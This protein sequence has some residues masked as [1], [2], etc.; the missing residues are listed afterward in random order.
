MTNRFVNVA[1]TVCGDANVPL[2]HPDRTVAVMTMVGGAVV[3]MVSK[4]DL[5]VLTPTTARP[6]FACRPFVLPMT[7]RRAS[8]CRR[9]NV[10]K[11]WA[12]VDAVKD[13]AS[14]PQRRLLSAVSSP[15]LSVTRGF[16]SVHVRCLCAP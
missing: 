3:N 13:G 2:T 1:M 8:D 4:T 9:R 7:K 6:R 11:L 14:M 16:T 10:C 15:L 12:R 5:L